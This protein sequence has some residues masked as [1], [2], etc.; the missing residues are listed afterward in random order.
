MTKFDADVGLRCIGPMN[1]FE[2]ETTGFEFTVFARKSTDARVA[3]RASS[4]NECDPV[5]Q[6]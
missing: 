2:I 6:R 4:P 3:A 1:L 5:P